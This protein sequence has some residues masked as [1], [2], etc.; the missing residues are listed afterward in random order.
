[1]LNPRAVEAARIAYLHAAKTCKTARAC[2]ARALAAAKLLE[3]VPALAE[4]SADE[5]MQIATEGRVTL[6]DLR[7]A[8][9]SGGVGA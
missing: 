4:R 6:N 8:A 5:A 7:W 1:M 2:F 9:F 3:G